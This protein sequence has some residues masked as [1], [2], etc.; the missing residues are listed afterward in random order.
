MRV[1]TMLSSH[2][3]FQGAE[4]WAALESVF[5]PFEGRDLEFLRTSA[6]LDEDSAMR[7]LFDHITACLVRPVVDD[8]LRI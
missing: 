8:V 1:R 3:T 5:R 6:T 4:F 2:S 7:V